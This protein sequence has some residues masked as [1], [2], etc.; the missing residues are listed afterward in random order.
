MNI[1][2]PMHGQVMPVLPSIRQYISCTQNPKDGRKFPCDAHGNPVNGG[3]TDTANWCTLDEAR[4]RPW[5][6]GFVLGND[7]VG[8]DTDSCVTHDASGREIWSAI[9]LDAWVSF[10]GAYVEYSQS[11]RGLHW[12]F[13]ADLPRGHQ[14]RRKDRAGLEIYSW[15]RYFQLG[16]HI[17]GSADIDHTA[18]LLSFMRR[19]GLR[20]EPLML[21]ELEAWRDPAWRGPED[22]GELVRLI[23]GWRPNARQSVSG[24]ATVADIWR[25][26]AAKLARTY[27]ATDR[28]DGLPYDAS[29]VDAALMTHL[30]YFTG[31]DPARM[32]RLF[33]QWPGYRA[34]HY[35]EG[36]GYRLGRIV[37]LGARGG[38]AVYQGPVGAVSAPPAATGELGDLVFHLPSQKVYHRPTGAFWPIG[39]VDARLPPVAV[40]MDAGGV[41]PKT[42]KPSKWLAQHQAVTQHTWFPGMPEI[43]EGFVLRDGEMVEV[44]GQRVLNIYRAATPPMG[45]P[46][47]VRPWLDHVAMLYPE[48]W[49]QIVRWLAWVAQNPGRKL[50]YALVLGGGQRIG[51]DTIIAPLERVVGKWNRSIQSPEYILTSQFT[52]YLQCRY[53]L[54]NEMK[55]TG[56]GGLFQL[57]NKLKGIIAAPPTTHMINPKNEA[58]YVIPNVNATIM[59]TNY[60]TGGMYLPADDG[61]HFVLWSEAT[62]AQIGDRYF[63]DLWFGWMLKGGHENCAAYLLTVDVSDFN[64][65]QPPEKTRAF[66]DMVESSQPSEA[67]DLNDALRALPDATFTLAQLAWVASSVCRNEDLSHWLK[68]KANGTKIKRALNDL[69]CTK[70]ANPEDQQRGRWYINGQYVTMYKRPLE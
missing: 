49:W 54:I 30:S 20:T 11:G 39:S 22:D 25:L 23:Q 29:A 70:H 44:P 65:M 42:V 17:C 34:D 32:S 38:K 59:T 28:S 16:R 5:K 41:L 67:G 2:S 36:G 51:K 52:D 12:I 6:I 21:A 69:G 58:P 18:A 9:A 8:V 40:G 26:D 35:E 62:R 45:N 55:D 10:P 33:Q 3:V 4:S 1:A 15:G 64:P 27:P 61:R 66:W 60:Q 47:D 48:H 24:A 13:R 37:Q 50:N 14:T 7:Y 56:N 53:L 31:R 68:N 57:Y 19:W 43:I 46:A 63:D